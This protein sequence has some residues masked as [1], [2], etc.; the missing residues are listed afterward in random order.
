MKFQVKRI[1]PAISGITLLS[2][3]FVWQNQTNQPQILSLPI[4]EAAIYP[5]PFI[6]S[7]TSPDAL[8]DKVIVLSGLQKQIDQI[9]EKLLQ[10]IHQSPDKPDDPIVVENIEKI[11]KDAYRPEFFLQQLRS[12]LKQNFDRDQLETLV[13]MYNTPLMQRIT[14]IE[15]REFDLETFEAFIEGVIRTSLPTNRLRQL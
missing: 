8:I 6:L 7:D 14:E 2:S 11:V 13:R 15:N 3:W 12:A 9:S 4:V 5:N 10:D 1:I